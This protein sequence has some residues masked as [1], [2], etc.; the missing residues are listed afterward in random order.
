MNVDAILN[1]RK[2]MIREIL[3]EEGL[4]AVLI[5]QGIRENWDS[6]LSASEEIPTLQPFGRLNL[7]LVT[8]AGEAHCLCA[9]TNHP[10]DF[11]HYPLFDAADFPELFAQK[12]LGLV[13]PE[14]LLK[15][16][17]DNLEDNYP[18]LTYVDV[19]EKFLRA[20]ARKCPEEVAGLR[21]AAQIYDRGFTLMPWLLRAGQTE[22][23]ITA[24]F[25]RRLGTLGAE[26]AFLGED[27]NATTLMDLTAAPQ[28]GDS[29]PEPIPYPGYRLQAGDR[30]NLCVCGYLKGGFAG[31]LG[32]CYVLGQAGAETRRCWDLAVQAQHRAAELLKPGATIRAV[33]EQVEQELVRP[34]GFDSMGENC[35]Y[36]IGC[37]RTE[38]PRLVDGSRDFPVEEGMTLVIAPKLTE[39]GKDPY[40]CMDMF[41]VTADGCVRLNQT[42]QDLTE[43]F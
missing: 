1:F 6:W 13:N 3:A 19:T 40:C 24:E 5:C 10:C 8:A 21:A 2:G 43:L 27:P 41:Q 28:E 42:K 35:I 16:T 29:I 33:V 25:R 15:V 32:R 34:N 12:R 20:K 31:A 39:P 38:A 11:P 22:L 4:D 17:R 26:V 30:V 36:G 7:F 23:Q 9:Y 37:S 18:G 14:C